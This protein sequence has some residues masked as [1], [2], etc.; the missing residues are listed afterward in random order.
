MHFN[1]S[2]SPGVWAKYEWPRPLVNT[3]RCNALDG[4]S[5]DNLRL[6]LYHHPSEIES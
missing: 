5:N 1:E 4:S 6:A 2:G 3:D